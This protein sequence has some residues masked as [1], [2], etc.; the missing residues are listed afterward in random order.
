MTGEAGS[1][2]LKADIKRLHEPERMES[3]KNSKRG[4]LGSVVVEVGDGDLALDDFEE[5]EISLTQT[6]ATLDERRTALSDLAHALGDHVDK[7][8]RV[9]D[10]LRGL[11]D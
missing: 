4:S 6:W 1:S 8:G 3:I 2:E 10:D 7:D 5:G 11:F 9:F